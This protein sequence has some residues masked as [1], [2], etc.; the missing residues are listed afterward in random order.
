MFIHATDG[1][2]SFKLVHE[3]ARSGEV[4]LGLSGPFV[5]RAVIIPRWPC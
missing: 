5:P 2:Y 3:H 1:S 4:F